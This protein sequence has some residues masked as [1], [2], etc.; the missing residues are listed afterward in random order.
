MTCSRCG[1]NA[2]ASILSKFN[3]DEICL[4]C[5]RDEELAPGYREADEAEVAHVRAGNNNY[6]GVGLS[7]EDHEFLARRRAERKR[8]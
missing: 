6:P 4:E 2:S 7:P 8:T 5:K 1:D 3:F